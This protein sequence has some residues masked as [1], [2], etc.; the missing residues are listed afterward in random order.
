MKTF[1]AKPQEVQRDWYVIDAKGKVLGRVASEVARRLRGKHKPE[2]TPHVDTGD[3]IVIINASEIVV[4][5][6]KAQDKKYYRHSGYPG[7]VTETTF[8]KMQQRFPGRAIQKAVKGMLPKGPLGY[9][10]AKKL[11]VY[12]GAEHPHS[13]QQPKPLEF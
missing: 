12:A 10:M 3:Y 4:T 9:A 7:G 5:G 1:V 8:E 11:K 6:N 13:A 2:F